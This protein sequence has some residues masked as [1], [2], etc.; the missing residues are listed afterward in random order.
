M[1][2]LYFQQE[3]MTMIKERS[4]EKRKILALLNGIMAKGLASTST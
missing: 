4:L 2:S 1:T 3:F